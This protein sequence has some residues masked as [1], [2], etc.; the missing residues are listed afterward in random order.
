[1]KTYTLTTPKD[2]DGQ[3]LQMFK[4]PAVCETRFLCP[5]Q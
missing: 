1:M 2:A 4:F 3:P 5:P